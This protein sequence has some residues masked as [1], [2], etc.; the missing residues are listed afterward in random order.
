VNTVG[1]TA[2][3]ALLLEFDTQALLERPVSDVMRWLLPPTLLALR[4]AKWKV[5]LGCHT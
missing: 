5:P 4:V 3:D 2:V 1:P